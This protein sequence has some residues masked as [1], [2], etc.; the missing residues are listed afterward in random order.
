M[1]DAKIKVVDKCITVANKIV[2]IFINQNTLQHSQ[3]ESTL[4][5]SVYYYTPVKRT[6]SE[7]QCTIMSR[8]LRNG[9]KVF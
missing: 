1:K 8:L 7:E 4:I 2:E 9:L 3:S 5:R 6:L